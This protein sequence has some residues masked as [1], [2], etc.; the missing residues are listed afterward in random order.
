LKT[1]GIFIVSAMCAFAQS[2]VP[3]KT[4]ANFGILAGS[5][6]TNTGNSVIAGGVGVSPGTSITGFPPGIVTGGALHSADTAA[7]NAQTDLTTAYLNAAGQT[8][9]MILTG[10]D[11]GTVGVLGPGVYCFATSAQLTGTLTLNG[12]GNPNAIFIF[13]TG[14]TLTTASASIVQT[15]NGAQAANVFWQ[16]GS[17]ATLGSGSTF[18][19]NIL[20]LSSITSNGG[21]VA[22]SLLARNGAVTI[23]AA[24][25][26]TSPPLLSPGSPG[27]PPVT[28][29]G[30]PPGTP[31]P[32]S[33]LMVLIG[34]ACATLYQTRERW[35][36]VL[37]NS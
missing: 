35:L 10:S 34:L 11:L 23:S 9:T 37:K 26:L 28:G 15:I 5:A 14:S 22:G 13:Q 27:G 12:G 31:I 17:S 29:P 36:R 16:I 18:I 3:L 30:V 24:L 2:A 4:A 33:F 1:F 19:G 20:A 25:A 21:A 32:S 6:V 7:A 8:C